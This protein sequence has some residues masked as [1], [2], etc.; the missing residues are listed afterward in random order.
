MC[1][2][3][4]TPES[5]AGRVS[6]PRRQGQ[7]PRPSTALRLEGVGLGMGFSFPINEEMM[8]NSL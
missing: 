7:S 5:T 8:V 2:S 4:G 1:Y 3:M 6:S